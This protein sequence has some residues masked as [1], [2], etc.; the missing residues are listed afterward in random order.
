M[1]KLIYLILFAF[2]V[3]SIVSCGG[4]NEGKTALREMEK[5]VEK[6]EKDKD[7]LTAEE[8]KELAVEFEKNEKIASEAADND[9]LG[10]AGNMKLLGL[11]AR[12]ATAYGPRMMQ[13]MLPNLSEPLENLGSDLQK[14]MDALQEDSIMEE[15][16]AEDTKDQDRE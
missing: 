13:D 1:K 3:T 2:A 15:A 11:T 9:K 4:Q 16:L 6:A 10:I 12:W 7:K 14:L 5:I 8:W